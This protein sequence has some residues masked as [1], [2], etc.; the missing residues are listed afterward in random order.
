MTFERNT[1]TLFFSFLPWLKYKVV[2]SW[3]LKKSVHVRFLF[4]YTVWFKVFKKFNHFSHPNMYMT[5]QHLVWSDVIGRCSKYPRRE[6]WDVTGCSCSTFF[7]L[8]FLHSLCSD[9]TDI[10]FFC[11]LLQRQCVKQ[12]FPSR[13]SFKSFKCTAWFPLFTQTAWRKLPTQAGW[14]RGSAH[15]SGHDGVRPGQLQQ[16]RGVT[17]PVTLRRSEYWR[18]WC[19]GRAHSSPVSY[20]PNLWARTLLFLLALYAK[21]STSLISLSFT[22]NS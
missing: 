8:S 9:S 14:K 2:C 10:V 13:L 17:V 11:T 18:Q 1:K 16:G 12:T 15:V 6:T 7:T 22:I 3:A 21:Y 20:C 4:F 19:T 5:Q